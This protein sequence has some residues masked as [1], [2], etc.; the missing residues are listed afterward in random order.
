LSY[1]CFT[2]AVFEQ[3]HVELGR[4]VLGCSNDDLMLAE[5]KELKKVIS[6]A[7]CS[8]GASM[9]DA[10][11]I[12][13]IV[14]SIDIRLDSL[15]GKAGSERVS[16]AK[17]LVNLIGKNLNTLEDSIPDDLFNSIVDLAAKMQDFVTANKGLKPTCRTTRRTLTPYLRF[18]RKNGQEIQEYVNTS[19]CYVYHNAS[20]NAPHA[21]PWPCLCSSSLK[22]C[23]RT[24]GIDDPAFWEKWEAL[25]RVIA[26]T[27]R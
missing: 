24:S 14:G 3:G 8:E 10:Q 16:P 25:S 6:D 26:V 27:C 21:R 18:M 1:T 11:E 7:D 13:Q 17:K 2:V 9:G 15:G 4:A 22:L 19:F 20:L 23:S 12:K 5:L